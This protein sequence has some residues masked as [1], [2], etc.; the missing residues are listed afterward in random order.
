MPIKYRLPGSDPVFGFHRSLARRL[1]H[2]AEAAHLVQDSLDA[3]NRLPRRLWPAEAEPPG[4]LG[5][6]A[7]TL[8]PASHAPEYRLSSA[9]RRR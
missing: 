9:V 4:W 7:T 3:V 8:I 5:W 6:R 2:V 1:D